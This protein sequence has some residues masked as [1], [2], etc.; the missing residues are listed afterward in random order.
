MQNEQRAEA[1]EVWRAAQYR[2]TEDLAAGLR[3]FLSRRETVSGADIAHRSL[4]PRFALAHGM[5]IAIVTMVSIT[6]VSAVVHASK[7]TH[8]ALRATGPMPAVNIP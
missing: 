1:A 4:K 3:Y 6:S 2:R 7:S 5:A 8:V